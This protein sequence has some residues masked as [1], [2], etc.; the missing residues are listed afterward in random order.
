MARARW[1]QWVMTMVWAAWLVSLG[2]GC[3]TRSR[4]VS[5][6]ADLQPLY[7]DAASGPVV[8]RKLE[9]F[10]VQAARPPGTPPR[11]PAGA[12][13]SRWPAPVV[14]EVPAR[15]AVPADR[16]P[17]QIVPEAGGRVTGGTTRGA[18]YKVV[19]GDTLSSIAEKLYGDREAWRRIFEANRAQLRDPDQ[20]K[21]G[22][23]LRLP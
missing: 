6:G 1:Q 19:A 22:M 12:R 15:A 23:L 16:E 21:A 5:W 13:P 18:V 11:S 8:A 2:G 17:Y 7:P 4:A 3:A 9:P 14:E 10:D 20:L